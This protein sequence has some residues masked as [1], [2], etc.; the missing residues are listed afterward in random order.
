MMRWAG[1]AAILGGLAA[2]VL[3][4]PFATAFF[5]A[6]PGEDPLPFWFDSVAARLD[7]QLRFASPNDVYETYGRLYNVVYLLFLPLV[8]AM[9]RGRGSLASRSETRGFVV[10]SSGLVATTFG[11]AGDYWGNGVGFPVEVLGLLAMSIG[12]TMWG[13]ALVRSQAPVRWAWLFVACGPG[14]LVTTVLMGHIPSGPTLS[15][16]CIWVVVGSVVVF[17]RGARPV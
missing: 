10:L 11:V 3:T 12:V 17:G 4:L 8:V 6:Y 2:I 5:L 14:A 15:F 7:S 16:A 9:H 13:I 1:L